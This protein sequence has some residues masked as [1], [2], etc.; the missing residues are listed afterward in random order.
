MGTLSSQVI[1]FS[2]EGLTQNARTYVLTQMIRY[3]EVAGPAGVSRSTVRFLDL[4]DKEF[5]LC[6]RRL[7]A[8]NRFH[9]Q[10]TPSKKQKTTK[11]Q[12]KNTN[13]R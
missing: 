3:S 12:N 4:E 6:F 10:K 1:V 8:E 13:E 9:A 5:D 7:G 2:I 11:T